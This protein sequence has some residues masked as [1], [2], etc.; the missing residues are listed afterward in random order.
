MRAR[1]CGPDLIEEEVQSRD[2]VLRATLEL[3]ESS[4][5]MR[6]ELYSEQ[7]KF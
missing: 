1:R 2:E 3:D 5:V 4:G 7:V 6:D